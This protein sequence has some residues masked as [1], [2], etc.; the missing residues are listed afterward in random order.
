MRDQYK[1]ENKSGFCSIYGDGIKP[2]ALCVRGKRS[3]T[4]LH[5][6]PHFLGFEAS[7]DSNLGSFLE[8]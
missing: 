7:A 8:Y 4:E 6:Q 3:A 5:P 1:T 2:G